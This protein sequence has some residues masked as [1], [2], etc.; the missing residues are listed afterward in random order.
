MEKSPDINWVSPNN[1]TLLTVL[2]KNYNFEILNLLIKSNVDVNVC[3]KSGE[4]A[5]ILLF[6]AL[7]TVDQQNQL[8]QNEL[9]NYFIKNT[10]DISINESK[11]AITNLCKELA[12]KI[13]TENNWSKYKET[14]GSNILMWSISEGRNDDWLTK[15]IDIN[16]FDN[17]LN[18]SLFYAIKYSNKS[19]ITKLLGQGANL[20]TKNIDGK[21]PI[22]V[23]LEIGNKDI[24]DYLLNQDIDINL[25]DNT[26]KNVLFYAIENK[27]IDISRILLKRG[28]EVDIKSAFGETL[29]MKAISIGDIELI[30]TLIKKGCD[31]NELDN[32]GFGAVYF[33][34]MNDREKVLEY[35]IDKVK[36][37]NFCDKGKI[38]IMYAIKK[39]NALLLDKLL[40]KGANP[41][42]LDEFGKS[43]LIETLKLEDKELSTVLLNS[44]IDVNFKSK[45]NELPLIEAYR[46]GKYEATKKILE[47]AD[48]SLKDG[49]GKNIYDTILEK[50]NH[51]NKDS[52]ILDLVL[53][54]QKEISIKDAKLIIDSAFDPAGK[55][56]IK[57]RKI[58][59]YQKDGFIEIAK[60]LISKN[61]KEELL[62]ILE[63]KKNISAD[64]ENSI[65]TYAVLEDKV[66]L[67]KEILNKFFDNEEKDQAIVSIIESMIIKNKIT[68]RCLRC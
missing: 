53:K 67:T 30:K 34:V 29:L 50:K 3:D 48:I 45:Y 12:E 22:M 39:K 49:R 8:S 21:T 59:S 51:N 46:N 38:A 66:D 54:Q 33:A 15:T 18:T 62:Y 14:N 25:K 20:N 57:N 65:I 47:T 31:I 17:N 61:K 6:K 10:K 28:S 9:L 35:I 23:A 44:Q 56:I 63:D 40:K 26:G 4:S 1:E 2:L 16:E 55:N 5:M 60:F 41:N 24:I 36:Y 13:I 19:W 58:V 52:E 42:C 7:K 43:P 11:V 37:G 32:D 68:I 27:L 64:E